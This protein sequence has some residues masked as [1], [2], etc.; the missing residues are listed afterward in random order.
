MIFSWLLLPNSSKRI[1]TWN[2]QNLH[3][4][5]S[6]PPFQT[7]IYLVKG[8]LNVNIVE[9]FLKILWSEVWKRGFQLIQILGLSSMYFD[10]EVVELKKILLF[11]LALVVL[12][13]D[14]KF[15]TPV[16][17]LFVAKIWINEVKSVV[18]SFWNC[19]FANT[20]WFLAKNQE[21]KIQINNLS[22]LPFFFFFDESASGSEPLG[23][24]RK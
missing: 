5:K 3:Q 2:G 23:I 15:P 17:K 13:P 21:Q 12:C 1:P 22:S 24:T 20:F 14:P 8:P 6:P 16:Q 11:R 10:S 9:Q 4:L 19:K 7:Q 18:L